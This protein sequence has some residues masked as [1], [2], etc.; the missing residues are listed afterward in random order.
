MKQI[1]TLVH[2]Q[3]RKTRFSAQRNTQLIHELLV[4]Q[5]SISVEMI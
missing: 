5:V 2:K 1:F 4:L 3:Q